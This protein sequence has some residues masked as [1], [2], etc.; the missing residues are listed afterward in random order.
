[1]LPNDLNSELEEKAQLKLLGDWDA[2]DEDEIEQ[3][4]DRFP[5]VL[6]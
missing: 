3:S 1:M 5:G 2:P 6:R 4:F